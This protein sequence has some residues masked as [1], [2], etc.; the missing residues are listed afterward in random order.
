MRHSI[1]SRVLFAGI[2]LILLVFVVVPLAMQAATDEPDTTAAGKQDAKKGEHVKIHIDSRGISVESKDGKD[3]AIIGDDGATITI[4]GTPELFDE[5]TSEIVRF[6]EDVHVAADELVRGDIACFGGD[7]TVEGRVMGEVVVFGGNLYARS[8]A[9]INGDAVVIG[10]KIVEDPDVN[11]QGEKI[12][13]SGAIPFIGFAPHLAPQLHLIGLLTA[14][15]KFIVFLGIAFLILLVMGARV[16]RSRSFLKIEYFKSFGW[17]LLVCF[18]GTFVV[19]ILMVLL[20]IT[21]IGIPLAILLVVCTVLLLFIG[22]TV[23]SFDLGLRIKERMNLS[24]TNNYALVLIGS[25]A[26]FLPVFIGNGLSVISFM[27]GLGLMVKI[28]ANL[29]V[30]FGIICG[31]GALFSSRFGTID[32]LLGAPAPNTPGGFDPATD[33]VMPPAPGLSTEMPDAPPEMP[34]DSYDDTPPETR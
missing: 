15:I 27:W 31:I 21:L 9:Q 13:M 3:A 10:G 11:I 19:P 12:E 6:G 14:P 8:G 25:V 7:V 33:P 1:S 18:I 24:A 22:L 2:A 16:T 34:D 26:L 4:K 5:S 17:G 23:F 28:L 32:K 29:F 20:A 30:L